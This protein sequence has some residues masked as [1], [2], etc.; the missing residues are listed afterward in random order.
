MS[1]D[2]HK[3]IFTL[4]SYLCKS[5]IDGEDL[6]CDHVAGG[7]NHSLLLTQRTSRKWIPL[8]TLYTV[9]GKEKIFFSSYFSRGIYCAFRSPPSLPP[10]PLILIFCS[11]R[12]K[13][14]RTK[15]ITQKNTIFRPFTQLNAIFPLFNFPFCPFVLFPLI[16]HFYF[17]PSAIPLLPIF[18]IYTC[19]P[20]SI[21]FT[22]ILLFRDRIK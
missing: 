14:Q 1:T 20:I 12:A 3:V 16:P 17:F 15:C 4:N 2:V 9:R 13:I 22:Y 19:I 8:F 10:P 5:W 18:I 6:Y 7:G 11:R 21:S